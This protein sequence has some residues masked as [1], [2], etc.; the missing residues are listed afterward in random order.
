ML[1]LRLR[2]PEGST[3]GSFDGAMTCEAFIK[4]ASEM[5]KTPATL[6]MLVGFPPKPCEAA[7][8][9]SL[10][11]AVSSG[12]TVVFHA[13]PA[14]VAAPVPPPTTAGQPSFFAPPAMPA[15]GSVWACPVCTLENEPASRACAA[16]GG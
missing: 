14:A 2:G 3:M 12:D 5:L 7:P 10:S 6:E 13:Q 11:T 16:C 4:T 8:D 1:R 15:T 9:A